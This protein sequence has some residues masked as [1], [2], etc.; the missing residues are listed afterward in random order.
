MS[1]NDILSSREGKGWRKMVQGIAVFRLQAMMARSQ[2]GL[3]A[4]M[5]R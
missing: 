5:N 2:G 1:L 4:I 3:H